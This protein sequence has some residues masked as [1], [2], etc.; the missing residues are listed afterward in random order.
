MT[1]S[2]LPPD[3]PVIGLVFLFAGVVKGIAGF[4]QPTISLALLALVRPL[5]EAMA[6][7]LLP[8]LVA[9]VWQ[10]FVG[11]W[12]RTVTLRLRSFLLAGAVACWF[13]TG[14]LARS[15]ARLLSGGLGLLLV[16]SAALAL[17]APRLPAPSPGREAWLSPIMGAVSGAITGLTGSFLMPAAPWLQA[18]R[19]PRDAFVQAFGIGVVVVTTV[20]ALGMRG[21]G[22]L[23]TELGIASVAGLVPVF[24]GMEIG[25]RLRVRLSEEKFRRAVQIGLGAMGVFLAWRGL[26]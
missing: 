11:S 15:D 7:I 8:T 16:A 24:L 17:A 12:L 5:P 14:V 18:I 13:A 21:E 22:M 19:L 10:A 9:N 26:V 2:F 6:L 23:P 1:A 3:A 4:G 20:L 25:R